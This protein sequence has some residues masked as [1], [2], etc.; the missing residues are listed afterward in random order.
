[1]RLTRRSSI[2][3]VAAEVARAFAAARIHSVLTGGACAAVYSGGS[4]QSKDLDF[5][6]GP[7]AR[8]S[9]LDEALT[10]IGFRRDA[11][12]YVHAQAPFYI[13]FPRGPLAIGADYRIRPVLRA[14]RFF[15]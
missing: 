7:G 12:R 15:W 4:Y 6:L 3:Q 10:A 1:M 11:D 14:N 5:I 9:Q 8:Q 13:E 2:G